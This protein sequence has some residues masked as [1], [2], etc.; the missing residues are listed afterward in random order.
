[1][2]LQPYMTPL[3]NPLLGGGA[4]GQPMQVPLVT[5]SVPLMAPRLPLM[6]PPVMPLA[7]APLGKSTL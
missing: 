7:P 3:G 5:P 4:Y 6:S 2:S 1:M